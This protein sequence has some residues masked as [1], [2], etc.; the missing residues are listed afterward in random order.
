MLLFCISSNISAQ[1]I[2]NEVSQGPSGSKEWVELLVIG[3]PSCDSTCV[4]LRGWIIDD[5]NG[6]F[7]SG[8]GTGIADGHMRFAND[9]QW[10]CVGYGA[11][12]VIYN[13]SDPD[14]ALPADDLTDSNGDCV[15]VI[16]GNSSLF[17]KDNSIPSVSGTSSYAGANYS[18]GGLWSTVQMNNSNDSYQTITPNNINQAYFAVS[19]GSN[20]NNNIIYLSGSASGSTM[21]MSNAV[22]NDPFDQANWVKSTNGID[23]TPGLPNNTANANWIASLNNNCNGFVPP[24]IEI[25]TSDTSVCAGTPVELTAITNTSSTP[26]FVWNTGQTGSPIIVTTDRDS[27]FTVV[28][29]V[30]GCVLVDSIRITTGGQINFNLANDTSICIGAPLVLEAPVQGDYLWSTNESTSSITVQPQVS[31]VYWLEVTNGNCI[32]M[33]SVEVTVD[34]PPVVDISNDTTICEGDMVSVSA[35]GANTYQWSNG[36]SSAQIS[37]SP[38]QSTVYSVTAS[39]GACSVI[40]S[41]E[42]T[43]ISNDLSANVSLRDESCLGA[44]DGEIELSNLEG[45]PTLIQLLDASSNIVATGLDSIY[46]NLP[47]GNYTVLLENDNTCVL[48]INNLVINQND[49]SFDV[50]LSQPDCDNQ[51]GSIEIITESWNTVSFNGDTFQNEYLFD[52]LSSGSYIV[53]VVDSNG[54][55]SIDTLVLTAPE[56]IDLNIGPDSLSGVIGETSLIEIQ[57][58]N[59]EM[60]YS[61]NWTSGFDLSCY[62]CTNPFLNLENSG[63]LYLNITDANNCNAIDSVFV[64][65]EEELNYGIPN[66][67]SPNSDGINDRYFV[68]ANA[69]LRNFTMKI[70]NRWGQ[71]IF[72]TNDNAIGWDGTYKDKLQNSGTYVYVIRFDNYEDGVW[73]Q[74]IEKGSLTLLR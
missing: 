24:S 49:F 18:S 8:S 10:A 5:N 57:L 25:F 38:V 40:E 20:N 34:I 30:S 16:P 53:E 43:V 56:N 46:Q 62:E 32:G 63:F 50:E 55:E 69:E 67:F 7:A 31:S 61:W 22:N 12:I 66:A 28:A 44:V 36:L 64:S 9:N 51:N 42:I 15:Y 71:K 60:P 72:E 1:L 33:D 27:T 54:C 45:N 17:E 70:F 39:D 23:H 26:N 52:A 13:S 6:T 41:V 21:F 73:K 47:A 19:W 29:N 2:I 11:M 74:K 3:N 48:E 59:G 14:P 58:T 37:V 68:V 4:D 65:V 35:S